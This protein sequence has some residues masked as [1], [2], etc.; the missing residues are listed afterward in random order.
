M[1][2][3][4]LYL[5]LVAA[6]LLGAGLCMMGGCNGGSSYYG[7]SV[8]T[9][10]VSLLWTPV[11]LQQQM[12]TNKDLVVLDCRK[13]AA[14]SDG[15]PYLPYD[16]EHITGAYYLDFF[17]FGDPYPTTDPQKYEAALSNLGLTR[18]TPIC[19]YDAGI[20][21]PQGKVFF[22]LERLGFSD[23]HILDGGFPVWKSNNYPTSA[24]VPAARTA[25]QFITTNPNNAI[26]AELAEMKTIYDTVANN[27][28]QYVLT[29]FR[30][31]PLYYGHKICPDAIRTGCMPH[32]GLLDWHEYYNSAT[33][34]FLT[35]T[36]LENVSRNAGMDPDKVNVLICN[37][38]WRTGIA[39]FVLR[40]LGWPQSNLIHYV[41]GIRAWTK[42]TPVQD[43]PMVSD[44]CYDVGKNMPLGK[45]FSGAFG[46]I[47]QRIFC[48]GGYSLI[49]PKP[50]SSPYTE[51]SNRVEFYDL[52]QDTW[53]SMEPLPEPLAF[54]AGAGLN[55]YFYVLGGLD[56]T[57]NPSSKV[58]RGDPGAGSNQWQLVATSM[59]GGK[60]GSRFSYAAATV[61][62]AIYVSGGLIDKDKLTTTNYSNEVLG[63][64]G[65]NGW[66][67]CT[68]LP[69]GRR[70]HAMVAIGTTLYV[71]GGFYYDDVNKK[72][73]FL[74]DVWALDTTNMAAGWQQKAD[75]AMTIAGH[76]AGVA[77]GKIYIPGGTNA[78]GN[79]Y[80]V[81]EFDPAANG[82]TGASRLMMKK[83]MAP[84]PQS[85]CIGWPRYWYF[86]GAHGNNVV[87]IGGYAG[88]T[89]NIF[90]TPNSG[91][92]HFH[93]TY[94]Y[95]VTRPDP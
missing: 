37:K 43:Y 84:T 62:N 65:N 45:R 88:G 15:T 66:T 72:G 9:N 63:Y 46:Q 53:G 59:I 23:V 52:P 94:V 39:Y 90:S 82:G 54:S 28:T 1:R 85:A 49:S 14:R 81:I 67:T 57:G 7:G 5:F 33:G 44:A 64:D 26:Y 80:D 18:T 51:A 30:E 13:K 6:A 27:S 38:G 55:G 69:Q 34:R 75:L 87:T 8:Q 4:V 40:H 70:C 21:N 79:K 86:I 32:C 83:G 16:D 41:G 47:G 56:S 60:N 48:A 2:H 42:A 76:G 74:K 93:Q 29:D 95:D 3:Q 91:L 92:T 71:L 25:T 35:K 61:G 58:Y 20:A 17:C 78:T 36:E 68:P 89:P 12:Q 31:P 50:T 24:V 22:H 10:P 73:V 19:L 77:N 11:T